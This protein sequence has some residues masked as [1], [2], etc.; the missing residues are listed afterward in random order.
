MRRGR[1]AQLAIEGLPPEE[2][3]DSKESQED[4]PMDQISGIDKSSS[5]PQ[6]EFKP[7]HNP[8]RH[9]SSVD[10]RRQKMSEGGDPRPV[11][12]REREKSEVEFD[13]D[14]FN[15]EDEG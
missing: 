15:P 4:N 14:L 12:L 10:A 1:L 3:S 5:E 11:Q 8:G 9:A 13:L 7:R 6:D 2:H